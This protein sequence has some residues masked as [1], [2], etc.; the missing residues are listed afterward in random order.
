[1]TEAIQFLDKSYTKADLEG[2]PDEDLLELRN[3]IASNLG[4][5]AV[6]QFKDHE[7][8]VEQTMKA[9]QKYQESADEDEEKPKA[10]KGKVKKEPKE[11]K[12]AKPCEAR[13]VK[14]PTRKMF[15]VMKIIKP[16]DGEEDRSHRSGN[17]RDG[18]MVI[19]AI[20][21]EGTCDWDIFNWEKQGYV[22]VVQPTDEEYAQRRAEWF[23]KHG[24]EDPETAKLRKAEERAKA[25]AEREAARE[26]KKKEKEAA[27]AAKEA[28]EAS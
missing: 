23:K 19:E 6:K 9:L 27:K 26:A 12:L 20:E 18:M 14:R 4:V 2:M 11:R 10:K 13:H 25:K 22:E 5:A 21:G 7:T 3:L 24:R 28:A 16:F 8:A 1:M 15:S 17:Y